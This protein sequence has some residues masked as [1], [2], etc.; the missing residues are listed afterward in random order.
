MSLWTLI[1]LPRDPLILL[2]S[3]RKERLRIVNSVQNRN[4][5]E[6]IKLYRYRISYP[7]IISTVII[8]AKISEIKMQIFVSHFGVILTFVF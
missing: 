4:C 8:S 2:K 3:I 5:D 7:A 6:E 1:E